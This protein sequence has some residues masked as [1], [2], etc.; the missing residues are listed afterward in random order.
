[1]ALHVSLA[2]QLPHPERKE[3]YVHAL[4]RINNNDTLESDPQ[5]C[6]TQTVQHTLELPINLHNL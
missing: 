2:Y 6:N 5:S 1:M 4:P 3:V